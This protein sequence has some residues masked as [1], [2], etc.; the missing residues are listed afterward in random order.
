MSGTS[1]VDR[2]G[3]EYLWRKVQ[4]RHSM[5]G[6]FSGNLKAF[7]ICVQLKIKISSSGSR[8][9]FVLYFYQLFLVGISFQGFKLFQTIVLLCTFI[10]Y[11]SLYYITMATRKKIRQI[12]SQHRALPN[13]NSDASLFLSKFGSYDISS[14]I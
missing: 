12:N 7:V 10:L 3:Q 13:L 8:P 11:T 14:I 4:V 6:S 9:Q 1:P 5:C 2:L